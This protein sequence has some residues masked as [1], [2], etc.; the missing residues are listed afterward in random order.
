MNEMTHNNNRGYK[1]KTASKKVTTILGD[2]IKDL[3]TE[4]VGEGDA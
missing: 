4:M 1:T 2:G 3:E